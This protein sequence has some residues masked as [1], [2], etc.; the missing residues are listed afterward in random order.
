[1]SVSPSLSPS[2]RIFL[3]NSLHGSIL[4]LLIRVCAPL[5]AYECVSLFFVLFDTAI[6][7]TLGETSVAAIT[8]ISQISLMLS[9][10]GSGLSVGCSVTAADRFGAGDSLR[11]R[12]FITASFS[13]AAL[14]ALCVVILGLFPAPLLRLLGA[15]P[16]I[17]KLGATY[18][19]LELFS[20]AVSFFNSV[21]FS[22]ERIRGKT[23]RIMLLNLLSIGIKVLISSSLVYG[24]NFQLPAIA[25]ASLLSQFLIFILSLFLLTRKDSTLFCPAQEYFN[26]K[27]LIPLLKISFPVVLERA[28]LY[29]GKLI[30]NAISVDYGERALGALG[31][32]N[33][34]GGIAVSPQTGIQDGGTSVLSQNLGAGNRTRSFKIF[35]V[36][37]AL[38]T[39]VS[40]LCFLFATAF[41]EPLIQLFAPDS[42]DFALAIHQIFNC[43]KMGFI[44][45]GISSSITA[46]LY[47][48]G[49]TNT[50]LAINLIRIF[51]L[52]I[53]TLLFLRSY[54]IDGAES[55]GLVMLIS[56]V[57][58]GLIAIFAAL[59]KFF[60]QPAVQRRHS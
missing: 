42:S 20:R 16:T 26:K 27:V 49:F 5:V 31:V 2:E 21:Y 34:L 14:C 30:V 44:P 40:T 58:T 57:G 46:L 55:L 39:T 37:L 59:W 51:A 50:T 33:T 38:N 3:D 19:Q 22:I 12:Q 36:L 56:N 45:L 6:S 18:F 17:T 43:E 35:W 25:L 15:S 41:S 4:P 47:A 60:L 29:A 9:A 10:I 48:N 1:M 23:Q 7:A 52:R 13:L 54:F 28:S 32:S 11:M 53:P 24:L 8:Y